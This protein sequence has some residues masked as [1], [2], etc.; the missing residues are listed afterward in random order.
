M[1]QTFSIRFRVVSSKKNVEGLA[2][3]FVVITSNKQRVSIQLKKK[4]KP[5]DFNSKKQCS[6]LDDVNNFILAV[7]T[8]IYEIQTQLFVLNIN[9][10]P[11]KIK[12]I[13]L[14]NQ[15]KKEWGLLE[16]YSKHNF[17]LKK[18]VNKTIVEDSYKKHIYVFNYLNDFMCKID[19]NINEIK[20]SFL[21]EFYNYL[22][23]T[24]NQS[25]NT[26]VG[27]MKKVKKIFNAALNE[28]I[29]TRNP[30]DSIKYKLNTVVPTFLSKDEINKIWSKKFSIL[31]VEKVRDVFIFNCLT[32]LSYVD[33]KNL[34]ERDIRQDEQGNMF[35]KKMRQKT[36]VFATIPLNSI[37]ISILKKY[38]FNLPVSSNQKMNTYLKE[39][40]DVCGIKKNLTMHVSR[41]TAATL[42]LNLGVSI[43]TV[44]A[45][46]GHSNL[47]ITQHYAKVIDN[48]I[49]N[50][51]KKITMI[52]NNVNIDD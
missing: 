45:V 44:S 10:T 50:D 25:N 16:L 31:R 52:E 3:L 6:T 15:I 42:M 28:N 13:F 1:Y 26:A 29:I 4:L 11:Q 39:I 51:L 32:G 8:K 2:P 48:T 35:I 49:I 43:T 23:T 21:K 14:G 9:P 12:E 47:K 20:S 17:E 19:I 30:F 7:R 34:S 5:A 40:A 36:K 18:L 38:N 22:I 41:H 37:A 46:L 24:K 27:N 33:C